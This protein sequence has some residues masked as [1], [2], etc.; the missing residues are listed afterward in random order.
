[1]DFH[2]YHCL[3]NGGNRMNSQVKTAA[4]SYIIGFIFSCILTLLSYFLVTKQM[5]ESKYVFLS[6]FGLALIQA[7][8][9]LIYFLHLNKD[10]KPNARLHVFLFMALVVLLIVGGSLWIMYNLDYR[11]M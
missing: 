11:T 1:M 8:I 10:E 7:W 6:I 2:F 4:K 5:L 3:F 9:Q